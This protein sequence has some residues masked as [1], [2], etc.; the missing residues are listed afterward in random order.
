MRHPGFRLM[1][2]MPW[3]LCTIA[4]LALTH[5]ENSQSTGPAPRKASQLSMHP[6]PG[7]PGLRQLVG[8]VSYLYTP[9]PSTRG[10]ILSRTP[11]L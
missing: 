3:S 11:T 8:E 9:C 5:H 1:S 10:S 4:F 6:L 2:S 7:H